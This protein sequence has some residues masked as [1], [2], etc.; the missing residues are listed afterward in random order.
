LLT[1]LVQ[2]FVD[3]IISKS[4]NI[5]KY[6]YRRKIAN[7]IP[8]GVR[9]EQFH[10]PKSDFRTELGL[11]DNKRY[12]LFLGNKKDPRKNHI[13]VEQALRLLNKPEIEL[14]TPYPASHDDVVKYLW[15][16]DVFVSAAFMEGSPNV[17]KEAMACNCP[18]VSTDVGDAKWVIGNTG[19]CF[20]AGFDAK[21]FADKIS[22][23]LDFSSKYRRT[24]GRERML[25]LG[26]DSVTIAKRII[27]VYHSIT[28]NR[29]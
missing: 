15:S 4:A 8:N 22:Q 6:V 3:A 1:W 2:P 28:K 14:I 12:V 16:T 24:N 10:I 17:I 25:A 29:N 21:D 18:M 27:S 20:L 26:L 23:A 13:L 19:G 11:N 7:I 5:D 9:M